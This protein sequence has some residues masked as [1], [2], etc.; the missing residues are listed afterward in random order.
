[1]VKVTTKEG[2]TNL[3]DVSIKDLI[4]IKLILNKVLNL[5][6]FDNLV[7]MAH[8]HSCKIRQIILLKNKKGQKHIMTSYVRLTVPY[9]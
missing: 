7:Q 3:F 4:K 1:M 8:N 6:D 2:R 9:L 5:T